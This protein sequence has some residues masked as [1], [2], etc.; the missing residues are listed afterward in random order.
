MSR[1]E[2]ML[3]ALWA[4]KSYKE[5]CM[6][7]LPLEVH[8]KDS[9]AVANR[10]WRSWIAHGI[11]ETISQGTGN[12]V[13]AKKLF[14]FL[15]AVHDLGKAT[16][17]FQAKT[18]RPQCRELD[19]QIEEKLR[20]AGLSMR[21]PCE[22]PHGGRTPHALATHILLERSGCNKNVA[23]ILSSHHGK[24]PSH[25]VLSQGSI[26]AYGFNYHLEGDEKA[27]WEKAQQSVIEMALELAGF[28]GLD[29]LPRP[30][31][32]A[33]VLLAG[34]LVM[35][36][37]IASNEECF[38]YLSLDDS[39]VGLD[40]EQR[41]N[42][43]W[44]IL[45]LSGPWE[46]DANWHIND[47]CLER[48]GFTSNM[49]QKAV[50]DTV[51]D[52]E[53]PGIVVMEAPMG[54]GKT[55]AAMVCA[56][57]FAAKS[58]RQGVFFALP[59]QA[60]SDGIFPR[61][62]EW[63]RKLDTN[64]HTIN[65]SHGKAQFNEMF[66]ALP[67]FEISAN[68]GVDEEG[69]MFVHEWFLGAKKALL[70]DFVVGTIDQ[71]LLAALRQKHLML[72]HLGLAGKVVVIDECHAYDAY[73]S[74]YLNRALNWL[75]AYSVPVIVLSAT[76]PA[77]K[78]KS[79]VEAYLGRD[80]L[81]SQQTDPLAGLPLAEE[82]T[83]A[84][85]QNCEYP[86]I[87]Y[88]DGTEIIQRTVP[89]EDR[90][91]T[92]TVD[93]VVETELVSLL[94]EKLTDGGC[95]GVLVNT[96]RRAQEI[97]R[98][99][100]ETFGEDV[101]RLL[102]SRFLAPDR[103]VKEREL[104]SELGKPGGKTLRPSFRIVVGTQVLEQSLDIDFDIMV[105]ELCPMDLLLQRMG[106]LH[107]HTRT[108][109]QKLAEAQCFII[110]EAEQEFD[111]ASAKIYGGYLL[112]RTKARLPSKV[113]L[114]D[115]I[116]PLV[117]SVYDD[118]SPI[119]KIEHKEYQ[120]YREQWMKI[121]SDKEKRARDFRIAPAWPDPGQTMIG[122]MDSDVSH[123]QSEATVRDTDESI[124]VLVVQQKSDTSIHFL[125]WVEDGREIILHELPDQV[126]AKVLACQ[127]IRLPGVLCAPWNIDKTIRELEDTN[128]IKLSL[129]QQSPWLKGELA[130]ILDETF[131]ATLGNFRIQYN[132]QE[133]LL[134]EKEEDMNVR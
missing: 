94:E 84:W 12:F 40:E 32:T 77:D 107:R 101:V 87:T 120:K 92:V 81:P 69:G 4:K 97:S 48:F 64:E 66:Q 132:R 117:Q 90:D 125:P 121:L 57:I 104:L 78:R 54:M 1:K 38:P 114:P 7:W 124:E 119:I 47:L 18:A 116:P 28:S 56:E 111:P 24:P 99:L 75:G 19:E 13:S 100:R 91:R 105:T 36:D 96:V 108:R 17:V 80:F 129:W 65:L 37:W 128:R 79:V 133:G 106:R 59:T 3:H 42:D 22:F 89:K 43:A 41:I 73:M 39:G 11:K 34:L 49:L 126:T 127:R 52:I 122:W 61:M 51:R 88:S 95:A 109:P 30:T 98:T 5:G 74:Q 63:A 25:T 115:D 55:E 110:E 76:L 16:P 27:G 15:S 113:T 68:I 70:A 8:I 86:L 46:A 6:Q 71:L 123:H 58:G 93:Q 72:R 67:S 33:Q 23:A 29:D 118:E 130:L 2:N 21:S 83:P 31:M 50:A 26:E 112:M 134:Y 10:L 62:M 103:A 20:M 131:H 14:V 45:G 9:A 44:E 85:I 82:E 35:T 60:T 53:Q 102:H